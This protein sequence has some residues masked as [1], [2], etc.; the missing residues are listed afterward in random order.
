MKILLISA[1]FEDEW[2]SKVI[3]VNSHYPLGLGYLHSYLES[4]GHLVNTLFLNDY[5]YRSCFARVKSELKQF[6]PNVVGFNILTNNRVSSFKLMEYIHIH[7]PKTKIIIGG[8]HT[9]VMYKQIINKYPFVVAVIGEGELTT[10][11]LIDSFVGKLPLGDVSGIA[12]KKAHNLIVTPKRDLIPDLDILPFPKH[13]IFFSEGRTTACIV[14]SRGCPFHCSFCVLDVIS[15]SHPRKRSIGNVIDEIELLRNS[16][17]LLEAVWIHDDQFFLD[18]QRVIDFCQEIVKRKIKLRFICSGR[19]K[20][21]SQDMVNWLEKAGFFQVLFGLESGSP[22]ILNLCHKYITQADVIN[23]VKLFKKTH[24]FVIMFLITGLVG[25]TDESIKETYEFVKKVQKIKYVFYH[26]I[27]I[28]TVYPGTEVY[29]LAKKAGMIND[30]YWLTAKPTPLY[31]VE[32]SNQELMEMKNQIL[33]HIALF[34]I[35]SFKGL[36]GQYDMIPTIIKFL[37]DYIVMLPIVWKHLFQR[38]FPLQ[39][40]KMRKIMY[41]Y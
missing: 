11:Q 28:L 10:A 22:R 38:F 17:P 35:F 29:D 31:T 39:Y 15:R 34:R 37:F 30:A 23:T 20:P 5:E 4:K 33:N 27:S 9:S 36:L 32:H 13:E 24:I 7:F 25:E 1:S 16:Y 6:N 19:F 21:V 2:R 12:Y 18:N 40:M 8:I 41:N 3:N 14:T 26:D